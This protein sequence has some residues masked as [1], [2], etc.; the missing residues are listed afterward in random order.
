MTMV[1]DELPATSYAVLGMLSFAGELS[2]YD[3]RQWSRSLRFFYWS[4]AQSQIYG[5]LRRLEKLGLVAHREV[6]QEGRPDKRLYRITE[7]GLAELRRWQEVVPVDPP[8]LKHS[9]ALRLFFGHLA[10][11][12]RLRAILEEHGRRTEAVIDELRAVLADL[13]DDPRWTYPA[14]VA[15][16]GLLHYASEF[17][18]VREIAGRL[19]HVVDGD[20]YG[21]PAT[22]APGPP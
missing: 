22:D 21:E 9:V 8:V 7:A 5:E 4:P 15:E 1:R 17:D 6:E 11:P 16:W 20:S 14:L 3:L 18:A 2:G 19:S 12:E 10:Q 13:G